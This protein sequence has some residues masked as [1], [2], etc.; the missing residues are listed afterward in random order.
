MADSA[1]LKE[2]EWERR[3]PSAF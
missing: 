2:E 3:S 1:E